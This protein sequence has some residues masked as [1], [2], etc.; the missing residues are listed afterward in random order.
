MKRSTPAI[1]EPRFSRQEK[2]TP[3]FA[4]EALDLAR[5]VRL[6][7]CRIPILDHRIPGR[8]ISNYNEPLGLRRIPRVLFRT[9][10]RRSWRHLSDSNREEG[11]P[12][13]LQLTTLAE[14]IDK[15]RKQI[16]KLRDLKGPVGEENTKAT[17]IN[18]ILS[19][20]GWDLQEIDEVCQ[21]YRYKPQANPVD[22]ALFLDRTPCLFVEAKSLEKEPG[23][24]KWVSQTLAYATVVGVPWCVLTN[25]DEYR[26]YNS[27]A[28]T[29]V[30]GKLF[31][32]VRVS[33]TE[34]SY[35]MDTLGLIS[36]DG[37]RGSRLDAYWRLHFVDSN[38]KKAIEALLEG[39]DA[40]LIKLLRRKTKGL[41]ASDV[42]AS[43][44]RAKIKIDFP[45]PPTV[46]VLKPPK[47]KP[48]TPAGITLADLIRAGII[49]PPLD[50]ERDY[51]G[52]HLSA[53]IQANGT[54]VFAGASYDSLSTAGGMARK[55][56]LGPSGKRPY[57]QTNGWTFWRYRDQTTGEL[58]DVDHL[59]KQ[60]QAQKQ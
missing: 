30:E 52:K 31:R 6:P 48:V 40:G 36:K 19:A 10:R 56:V 11:C 51:K 17:L 45:V 35:L 33:D 4:G 14:T 46:D 9:V 49:E 59:R 54:V 32:K 41:S 1:A 20:L 57:P 29:D 53:L 60:Y 43:L 2:L 28:K 38:V 16:Q 22:Y 55:S 12:V 44:K 21:Q 25:G 26:I 47:K 42:R 8:S 15:V 39:H 58:R 50:I 24:F 37:M 18:P 7:C 23:D 27:H 13:G 5:R 3:S 34:R